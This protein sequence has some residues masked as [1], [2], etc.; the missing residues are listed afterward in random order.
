[1]IALLVVAAL[2]VL[3]IGWALV[4]QRRLRA[5]GRIRRGGLLVGAATLVLG[6]SVAAAPDAFATKPVR[7]PAP[8]GTSNTFPAGTAC[9]F[10]LQADLV[11]GN[12]EF[13]LF[14]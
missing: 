7:M 9:L 4:L 11:G 12:R 2:V 10:T 14:D 5:T 6:C 13:T 8:I 1:M 3:L